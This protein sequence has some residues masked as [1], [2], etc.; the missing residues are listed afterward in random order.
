[1][2][3]LLKNQRSPWTKEQIKEMYSLHMTEAKYYIHKNQANDETHPIILQNKDKALITNELHNQNTE[4]NKAEYDNNSQGSY[5]R[6][7]E[8]EITEM[9][10][11]DMTVVEYC[12]YRNLAGIDEYS[13]SSA[14]EEVEANNLESDNKEG[15]YDEDI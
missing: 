13:I 3:L 6:W 1:M 8:D 7:M 11:M 5:K 4:I 2:E 14:G 9:G 12:D 10:E 15:W